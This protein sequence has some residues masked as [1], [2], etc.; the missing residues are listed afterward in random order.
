[1]T[2]PLLALAQ[3]GVEVVEAVEQE[4]RART[5][6]VAAAEQAVVEAEHGHDALVGVERR[7]QRRV[8]VDAQVAPEPDDRGHGPMRPATAS[9][10]WSKMRSR[11]RRTKSA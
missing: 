7:A 3:R 2:S 6:R 11:S 9:R 10:R 8:V 5:R 4:L 1:M